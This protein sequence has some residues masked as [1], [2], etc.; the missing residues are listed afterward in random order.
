VKTP[1]E[2]VEWVR[3]QLPGE[4]LFAD[5]TWRISPQ[6]FRLTARHVDLLEKLGVTLY[7]FSQ[8]CNLLYRQS[9][10]G[11][12]PR[13]ISALLE[14]G[15]PQDLIDLGRSESMKNAI[16]MVIRPDLI[17]T[18]EGFALCEMDSVP[19]GIGLTG[20]LN[21]TY[22]DLGEAVLGGRNGM[23]EGFRGIFPEGHVVISEEAADYRPEMEWLAGPDRV[24]AA[25]TYQA[26]GAPI[27]RFF[28]CFDWEKLS[29]L[30][31]TWQPSTAMTPPLK[32]VLEEKLWLALFWMKPLQDFWKREIGEKG[33]KL[34]QTIIPRTWVVDPAPLPPHA[35]IPELEVQQWAEVGKFSQKERELILKISGFSPQAWGSRGVS[36]GSD[37]STEAWQQR[38]ETALT[39]FS[40]H[41][42]I[43]QRFAKGALVEQDYVDEQGQVVTMKG[44]A[45]VC[46]YFF[47]LNQKAQL[48]GVLV[49]LCPADKKLLHGMRDAILSPAVA[50]P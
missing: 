42:Y 15:K 25:E 4:G 11:R 35:V 14:Q 10:A 13:W 16:P 30:R 2:R 44:R 24:K 5:K 41:P 45:R 19:G 8:A 47:I 7:R 43:L 36:V 40:Q 21:Q 38:L 34:L 37:L 28:E 3:G 20:W 33:Q 49:T 50:A 1:L 29:S 6:A 18:E 39:D 48:G 9:V 12:E 31:Q 26:N 17:L 46:P 22:A 32:A 23:Q 27:Y